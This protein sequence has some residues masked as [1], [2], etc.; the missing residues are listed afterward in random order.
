MEFREKQAIYIQIA[1]HFG[2]N[3]IKGIWKSEEKIPSVRQLAVELEVNPNTVMRTYSYLQEKEIITNKRGIGFFVAPMA[4]QILL[5]QMKSKFIK[6]ELPEFF[7]SLQLLGLS[8][9]DL[10]P[11]FEK[12]AVETS[13]NNNHE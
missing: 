11:Y 13:N 9:K 12:W 7:K 5:D 1:D 10:E 2:S 4:K 6:N 8:L 3:I